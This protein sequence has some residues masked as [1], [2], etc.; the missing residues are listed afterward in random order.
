MSRSWG[1]VHRE[2]ATHAQDLPHEFDE[3][4]F[5]VQCAVCHGGRKELIHRV[6]TPEKAAEQAGTT[7]LQRE[8]GS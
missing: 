5:G 1:A 7:G 2:T 6:P 8:I 3:T 4:G